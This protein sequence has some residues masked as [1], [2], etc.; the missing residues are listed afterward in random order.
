[1]RSVTTRPGPT[2]HAWRA[3]LPLLLCLVGCASEPAPAPIAALPSFTLVAQDGR[4]VDNETLGGRVWIANAFFTRCVTICPRLTSQVRSLQERYDA[5]RIE[6]VQLVSVSVDP[7]HDT[8]E[9]LAEYGRLHGADP[10]RWTLATGRPED[11]RALL[12]GGFMTHVGERREV[13]DGLFDIAHSGR[14]ILVDGR[15]R[16]RGFFDSDPAGLDAVFR[17]S[18]AVLNEPG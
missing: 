11:V 9:R 4:T 14:L 2:A 8:P 5:E 1:M 7:L 17:A 18:L 12:E 15:G 16:I 13:G 10:A 3:G 6:G